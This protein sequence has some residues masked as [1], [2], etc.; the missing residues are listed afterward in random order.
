[1]TKDIS[2]SLIVGTI[3]SLILTIIIILSAWLLRTRTPPEVGI[4]I[5]LTMSFVLA[6]ILYHTV[7]WYDLKQDGVNGNE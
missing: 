5:Y 2:Y 3:I 4:G 6:V 7:N 1:M